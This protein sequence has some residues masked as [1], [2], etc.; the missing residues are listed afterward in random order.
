MINESKATVRVS[1]HFEASPERIFDA[2]LDSE[3]VARFLFKTPAGEM[4]RVEIDPCVGGTYCIV[5]RRNGVDAAHTGKYLEVEKPARLVFTLEDT[6]GF[7]DTVVTIEIVPGDS[8]CELTLTHEGVLQ[9]Y[10]DKVQ[11]GWTMIVSSLADVTATG[12]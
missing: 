1:R 6:I 7:Q 9:E 5:E 3:K 11:D 4:Q 10:K 8:G 2:W 12:V